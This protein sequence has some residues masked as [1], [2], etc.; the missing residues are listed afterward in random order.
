MTHYALSWSERRDLT[1]AVSSNH[2]VSYRVE[3]LDRNGKAIGQLREVLSGAVSCDLRRD[4]AKTLRLTVNDR[5]RG[6]FTSDGP[7]EAQV[8]IDRQIRVW[9]SVF[10]YGITDEPIEVPIFTGPLVRPVSDEGATLVIEAQGKEA[11]GLGE[12]WHT[13]TYR[14]GAKKTDVIR[15]ILV[16]YLG[17]K[18]RMLDLA[19]RKDRLPKDIKVGRE[20]QP[21]K[22]A[23]RLAKSLGMVL[24]YDGYGVAV[25]RDRPDRVTAVDSY[26]R[27]IIEPVRR[28]VDTTEVINAVRVIGHDYTD[29]RCRKPVRAVAIAPASHPYSPQRLGQNGGARYLPRV[30]SDD[31]IMTNQQAQRRARVAL[32]DGLERGSEIEYDALPDP[33]IEVYQLR[34]V[35]T[36]EGRIRTRVRSYEL[37]IGAGRMTVGY[38]RSNATHRT[39]RRRA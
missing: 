20:E 11:Y 25:L 15:R 14:K 30:I 31:D 12:A 13:T 17:E 36:D 39:W 34:S 24:Y 9:Q 4:V 18:P 1:K 26:E 5:Q 7:G 22:V 6:P 19:D 23:K 32:Q 33:L 16:D 35:V 29:D 28:H 10:A 2:K 27:N 8:R 21:W 38:R 3:V 37:P